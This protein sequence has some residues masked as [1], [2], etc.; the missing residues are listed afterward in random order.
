MWGHSRCYLWF[1]DQRHTGY[2][3]HLPAWDLNDIHWCHWFNTDLRSPCTA[4][5]AHSYR[6]M[7]RYRYCQCWGTFRCS[8]L[9][10]DTRMDYSP[11]PNRLVVL[12]LPQSLMWREF[13]PSVFSS[14]A[15]ILRLSG[16]NELPSSGLCQWTGTGP[17]D[18]SP[19]PACIDFVNRTIDYSWLISVIM[20]IASSRLQ[21]D[22]VIMIPKTQWL[23]LE[24]P[25]WR[26][27]YFNPSIGSIEDRNN[28]SPHAIVQS[29]SKHALV[30]LYIS[31]NT[32]FALS[33]QF[34]LPY[35]NARTM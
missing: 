35:A 22:W 21:S 24:T 3:D 32:L 4:F 34:C 25:W 17:V 23:F 19:E 16:K 14:Y 27:Q 10:V 26:K 2:P 11:H 29:L 13:V 15:H 8:I 1:R 31:I 30:D 12:C 28:Y 9:C 6:P 5:S 33:E 18:I 7:L 20:V